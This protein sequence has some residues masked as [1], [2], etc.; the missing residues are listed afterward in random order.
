MLQTSQE[1]EWESADDDGQHQ[2]VTEASGI[3][4]TEVEEAGC[5][6]NMEDSRSGSGAGI[7]SDV[8]PAALIAL[9]REVLREELNMF[10]EEKLRKL[11]ASELC[12]FASAPHYPDESSFVPPAD[13]V[14]ELQPGTE[15][16]SCA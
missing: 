16:P 12:S 2:A 5:Q 4:T 13:W 1:L 10:A 8:A 7:P 9:C 15:M 6:W 11:V 3:S 14:A